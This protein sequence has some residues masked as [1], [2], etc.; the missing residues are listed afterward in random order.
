V[1]ADDHCV[2]EGL[3]DVILKLTGLEV[4]GDSEEEDSEE[5]DSEEED[6]EEEDS[7]EEDSEEDEQEVEEGMHGFVNVA[8]EMLF[9]EC[10]DPGGAP[11]RDKRSQAISKRLG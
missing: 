3:G 11:R 9:L 7:E 5:E 2:F 8:D 10:F 6:S 1:L 4:G